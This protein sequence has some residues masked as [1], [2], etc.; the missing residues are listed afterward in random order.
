MYNPTIHERENQ[1]VVKTSVTGR[2]DI[3]TPFN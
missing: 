1:P 2:V 3:Y